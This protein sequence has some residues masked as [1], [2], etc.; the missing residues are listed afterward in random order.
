MN[1]AQTKNRTIIAREDRVVSTMVYCDE[2]K[3]GTLPVQGSLYKGVHYKIVEGEE[4]PDGFR[5]S[6]RAPKPEPVVEQAE[7][8]KP[9]AK[10]AK[11]VSKKV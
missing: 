5:A 2:P 11:K 8:P 7:A 1:T 3:K 4:I 10:A 9:K 6:P